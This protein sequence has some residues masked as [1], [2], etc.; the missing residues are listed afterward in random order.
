MFLTVVCVS[1]SYDYDHDS[2][3]CWNPPY[4]IEML[5]RG[6]VSLSKLHRYHIMTKTKNID[7]QLEFYLNMHREGEKRCGSWA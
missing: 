6:L 5:G 7:F 2:V 3:R 1:A 4:Y